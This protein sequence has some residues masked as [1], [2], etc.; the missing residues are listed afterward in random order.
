MCRKRYIVRRSIKKGPYSYPQLPY[1][2]EL[3]YMRDPHKGHKKN[4][5]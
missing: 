1:D 4:T 5:L 2:E 3:V